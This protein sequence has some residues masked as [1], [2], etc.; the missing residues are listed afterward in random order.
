MTRSCLATSASRASL[1]VTSSEMGV[2]VLTPAERALADSRV[3]QAACVCDGQQQRSFGIRYSSQEGRG[4]RFHTNSHSNALL[5]E[6]IEGRAGDETSAEHQ[7]P[8]RRQG[9]PSQYT[10]LYILVSRRVQEL[11]LTFGKPSWII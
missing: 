3:R 2:A 6:D 8:T 11:S 9:T 4:V 5:R 10:I 7:Y 1:L